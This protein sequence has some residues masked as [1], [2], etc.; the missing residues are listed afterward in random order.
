[1]CRDILFISGLKQE[2][3]SIFHISIKYLYIFIYS[4]LAQRTTIGIDIDSA[5]FASQI[6]MSKKEQFFAFNAF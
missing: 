4:I 1:M 6:L 3:F 2:L 5:I